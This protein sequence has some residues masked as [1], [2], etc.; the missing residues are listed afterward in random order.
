MAA[1]WC[2]LVGSWSIPA[3]LTPIS[4]SCPNTINMREWGAK[5]L[6][7]TSHLCL[8]LPSPLL[9]EVKL[10]LTMGVCVCVGDLSKVL[11]G[12]DGVCVSE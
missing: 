7:E 8:L 10:H 4:Q 1:T 2:S 9:V 11:I 6:K 5:H 3:V 12:V